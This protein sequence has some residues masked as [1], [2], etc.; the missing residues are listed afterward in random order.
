MRRG[1]PTLVALGAAL[2]LLAGLG[3]G[4]AAAGGKKL[5]EGTVYDTSCGAACTPCPP[6]C[7]PVPAPQS[8]SDAVCAQRLIVCPLTMAGKAAA[9]PEFC[10]QGRPCGTD[11][12][13]WEGEGAIVH[14]RRRGTST[15][16]ASLPVV[17]GHFKVRLAPGQ[18]V[19]H[20]YL[21]EENCLHG[22]PVTLKV[23]A[24]M[25]S[26]VPASIDI[27]NSCVAHPDAAR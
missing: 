3:S 10:I 21:P 12:P 11:Y 23:E 18:Y 13:V 2:M 27:G 25:K 7:G 17:E 14:V 9:S 8:R 22:T 24:R 4:A 26:P 5:V 19:L 16:V 6:P 1:M 15:V 20:P